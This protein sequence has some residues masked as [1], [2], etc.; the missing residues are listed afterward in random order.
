MSRLD[1]SSAAP[2]S[3]R[4]RT[5]P[6]GAAS[7]RVPAHPSNVRTSAKLGISGLGGIGTG[8]VRSLASTLL[9]GIA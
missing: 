4:L 7:S 6:S 5:W 8:C 2:A 1:S 3:G 9:E